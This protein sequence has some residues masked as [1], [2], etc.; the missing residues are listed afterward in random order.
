MNFSRP[1]IVSGKS[2]GART[3]RPR[4]WKVPIRTTGVLK[5]VRDRNYY[6]PT[7]DT[8]GYAETI[9]DEMLG[10]FSMCGVL[11][12]PS[13]E[14][15]KVLGDVHDYLGLPKGN[16]TGDIY[17]LARGTVQIHLRTAIHKARKSGDKVI[18]HGIKT[19][20]DDNRRYDLLVQPLERNKP[21]TSRLIVAFRRASLDGEGDFTPISAEIARD[22]LVRQLEDELQ[23]SNE[24]L[25]AMIESSETANEELKSSNEELMSMNEELQSTN[26]ELET[27]QEELQ[28]LNE[29]LTTVNSEL[30]AN[31]TELD[32]AKS[33]LEN[34]L[35]S[36]DIAT[37]FIDRDFIIRQFTPAASQF[38]NILEADVGRVPGRLLLTHLQVTMCWTTPAKYC[39]A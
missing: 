19:D 23:L 26:E 28:A 33:D 11:L 4:K 5:G 12:N 6:L 3:Y 35:R 10:M 2:S 20:R 21:E 1:L 29:E 34:L 14:V 17:K 39:E 22:Q 7:Q 27:S 8:N 31:I 16:L 37:I 32:E 18:V 9:F 30:Q 25:Q 36:T 38:F 24:K 13:D 15:L